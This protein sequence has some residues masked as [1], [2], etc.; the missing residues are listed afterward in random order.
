MS[1]LSVW[2]AALLGA[3]QGATEFLP[4]SSSAHLAL[5]PRVLGFRDP[6][7]AF[8]LALHVGTL[9]SLAAVYGR[10]WY[11]LLK[12]AAAEPRGP[13]ARKLALLALATLPAVAAGLAFEDEAERL[14]RDP[15]R[16]AWALIA[17]SFVMAAAQ[18][19]GRGARGWEEAGW[20]AV[21]AVGAAQALA[22][23]PGVS[24]SGV[25]VSAGLLLGLAPAAAAELSF[26]LSAP[27]IAGAAAY[28]LRGIGVADVTAPFLCGV[29]VSA[30]TGLLAVR[31]FLA[32][33]PRRGLTPFVLYRLALGGA[34]LYAW[35]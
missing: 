10:T 31:V 13:A 34:L 12:D 9:L 33:L 4:V 16:I 18:R 7:L 24:R 22:I 30:L 28:K 8:D 5:T 32:L 11:G 1:E 2:Q 14:F 6:G 35:R 17:F 15:R 20:R 19:L 3:V 29:A 23:L 27:I 25:T 26:L 21:L